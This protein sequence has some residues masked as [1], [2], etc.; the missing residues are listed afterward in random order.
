MELHPTFFAKLRQSNCDGWSLRWSTD[1]K[2]TCEEAR[3][4]TV[5]GEYFLMNINK[6][7]PAHQH[8]PLGADHSACKD[9]R[10]ALLA[11]GSAIAGR[12]SALQCELGAAAACA[13]SMA[14]VSARG[15]A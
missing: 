11:Q 10:S 14:Q 8:A 13:W 4:T 7:Y 15:R 3:G 12:I 6:E 5:Q 1:Q 2:R 9:H